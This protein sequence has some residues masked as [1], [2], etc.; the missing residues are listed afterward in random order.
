VCL[1]RGDYEPKIQFLESVFTGETFELQEGRPR[2]RSACFEYADTGI[3]RSRGESRGGKALV[4]LSG[5]IKTPP[6]S[7]AARREIGYLIRQLQYGLPLE[8]PHSRPMPTIGPRCHEL[9]VNDGERSWRVICRTDRDAVLVLALF[10]K[11]SNKT[12][13]RV[14]EQTKRLLRLYDGD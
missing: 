6:L 3:M 1:S 12:P 9:R 8:M 2:G 7:R 10:S 4:I 14:I 5:D 13:R 11:K